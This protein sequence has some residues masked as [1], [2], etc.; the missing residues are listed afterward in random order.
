MMLADISTWDGKLF[1]NTFVTQE[2][3]RFR[4]STFAWRLTVIPGG[5]D[6]TC[7]WPLSFAIFWEFC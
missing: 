3:R 7:Q 6:G 2:V 1:K 5:L 4:G